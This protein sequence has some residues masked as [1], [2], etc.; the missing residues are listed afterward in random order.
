MTGKDE[1]LTR[2]KEQIRIYRNGPNVHA[3]F[4]DL[5]SIIEDLTI[6]IDL[7]GKTEMGFKPYGTH[8][9]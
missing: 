9:N 1:L 4:T 3:T 7:L 8:S 2:L 6:I 5:A